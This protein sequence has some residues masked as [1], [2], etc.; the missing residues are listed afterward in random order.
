L[1]TSVVT[2]RT[3]RENRLT[4]RQREVLQLLAE[5]LTMREAAHVLQI[6]TRTIAFHKYTIMEAFGLKTNS[7]LFR[8]AI[9]EGVITAS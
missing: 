9:K 1:V 8:F 2:L 5:G 6:T 7:D 4:P 3:N